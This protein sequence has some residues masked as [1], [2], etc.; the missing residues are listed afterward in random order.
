MFESNGYELLRFW[1]Q[2]KNSFQ[3]WLHKIPYIMANNILW[4]TNPIKGGHKEIYL[5]SFD[6]KF[7]Q[8][9]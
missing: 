3:Q 8:P 2:V 6:V 4:V 5:V 1:G 9:S 7:G